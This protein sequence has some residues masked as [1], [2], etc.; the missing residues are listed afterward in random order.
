MAVHIGAR[1]A[2]LATP[3]EVLVSGTV[4]DLVL[5]SHLSFENRGSQVLRGVPGKWTLC[6]LAEGDSRAAVIGENL[7]APDRPP[8]LQRALAGVGARQPGLTERVVAFSRRRSG[9]ST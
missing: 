6:A 7:D 5:G 4:R 3:G 2:A 9:R 8:I 1:I